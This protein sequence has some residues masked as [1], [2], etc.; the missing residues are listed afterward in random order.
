MPLDKDKD[1]QDLQIK[2]FTDEQIQLLTEDD[3]KSLSIEQIQ[4]FNEKIEVLDKEVEKRTIILSD[5]IDVITDAT[6]KITSLLEENVFLEKQKIGNFKNFII[7][8]FSF[9]CINKN[10]R[11]E[12][13]LNKNKKEIQE[14]TNERTDLKIIFENI[15]LERK[16]INDELNNLIK[17][18]EL[19]K[20]INDKKNSIKNTSPA[21]EF[22]CS[23]FVE[24]INALELTSQTPVND[25]VQ[26]L[27]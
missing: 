5:Y 26:N 6:S 2:I 1:K 12:K 4:V 7:T 15:S 27:P 11:I 10:K 22:S 21:K 18:T 19:W 14:K 25:R 24:E 9:G 3:I 16:K 23:K 20:N 13:K 8:M 17:L